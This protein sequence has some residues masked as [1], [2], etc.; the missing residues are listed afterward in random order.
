[1]TNELDALHKTHTWDMTALPPNK[2]AMDCK[3]VYKIKTRAD[4]SVEHY[5]VH[6]IAKGFTQEYG[7]KYEET[8]AHVAYLTYVQ[9]LLVIVTVLHWPL[10]HM[11]VKNSFLNNDILKEVYM[12][13]LPGYTHSSNRVFYLHHALYG[14][15]TSSSSLIC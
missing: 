6:L 7:I 1:M 14:L 12:Q 3:W 8:F 4:R 5:K 11:D 9:S 13:P 15:K 10:F 2:S